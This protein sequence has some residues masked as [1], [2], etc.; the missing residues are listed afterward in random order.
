[1]AEIVFV[2]GE[3]GSGKS[4]SIHSFEKDEVIILNASGKRLPFKGSMNQVNLRKVD[5]ITAYQK[6][7]KCIL[8][9][10]Q[11]YKAFVID[12]AG[13]L[14]SFEFFDTAVTGYQK[15]T[16][17]GGHFKDMLDFLQKEVPDDVIVY[18]MLH[19]EAKDTGKLGGKTI[20]KMLDEKLCLEGLSSI[21]LTTVVQDG[22]YFFKCQGDGSDMTKS[23]L[24]MFDQP[25]IPNDLRA[26]DTAIREY[27]GITPLKPLEKKEEGEK[28]NESVSN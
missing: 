18:I 14:M 3:S 26:V 13:Y 5:F 4:T 12:D 2:E 23:P 11:K 17:I 16:D 20:G 24:G 27:W 10:C 21:V 15:F 19:L 1:M 8:S 25:L 22:Q 6:I 9:N 7:K 28:E